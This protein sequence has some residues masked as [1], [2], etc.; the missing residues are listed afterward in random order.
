MTNTITART[1]LYLAEALATWGPNGVNVQIDPLVCVEYLLI[2]HHIM[3][4]ASETLA[5]G[6]VLVEAGYKL[7]YTRA[8]FLQLLHY[9]Y[10]GRPVT[11]MDHLG[12]AKAVPPEVVAEWGSNPVG[13]KLSTWWN[14][15]NSAAR[16]GQGGS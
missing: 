4:H 10:K 8:M 9:S 12:I 5:L 6:E 13:R 16:R 7:R 15:R 1:S 3:G 2:S 11:V 14:K